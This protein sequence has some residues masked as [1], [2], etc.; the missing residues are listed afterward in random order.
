MFAT[1]DLLVGVDVHRRTNVIQVM[2]GRGE[3]LT[4][5]QRVANNRSGT[6]A[7]IQQVADLAQEGA[8]TTSTSPLKPPVTTGPL[9]LRTGTVVDTG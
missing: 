3:M 8:L 1:T 7:F 6:A 2:N 9:L 5:P 4:K